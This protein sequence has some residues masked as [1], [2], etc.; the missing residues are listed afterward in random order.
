MPETGFTRSPRLH[1]GALVQLDEQKLKAPVLSIVPF[2]YNPE[3]LT[4][5]MTP[6]NPLEVSETDRGL[7]SP[8]AQPFDPEETISMKLELD[9]SD[10][11]DDD[12]A[13]AKEVGV[14]DRIAALERML[15]PSSTPFG[16]VVE[17][18]ASLVGGSA[19][20]RKSVPITFL[21]WGVG[22]IVPV[23]ITSYS[24]EE[25]LFLPSLRPVQADVTLQ[26][27]ILTPETFKCATGVG[28]ELA[29][30]IYALF[31]VQQNSLAELH[32]AETP[33]ELLALLPF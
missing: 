29:Q 21:V 28:V 30:S 8:Q 3:T 5:T 11:L 9:A 10:Q 26:L 19:P 1:K 7:P 18:A 6:W 20:N 13:I 33:D 22:R 32:V 4:R 14:A 16:Q 15:F 25:K 17:L 23:R 31:R 2:Q 27:Q 12:D 24:I